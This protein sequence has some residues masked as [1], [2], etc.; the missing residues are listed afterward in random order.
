MLLMLVACLPAD[1][2]DP[3]PADED[4]VEDPLKGTA[5]L[6]EVTGGECP[7]LSDSGNV[8]LTSNG[9]ERT[10]KLFLPESGAEGAPVLFEWY[11]LG[12]SAGQIASYLDLRQYADETG[13]VVVVP[14][15]E[16]SNAFE[17]GFWNG[18]END[19]ALYD[20]L[21]TCLS[22]ELKV[23]LGRISANGMSAGGL[24]TSYLGDHRGD[25]LATILA[26][27]GGTDDSTFPYVAAA[28]AF[29]ALLVHGGE[30]DIYADTVN[31]RDATLDLAEHLDADGHLVIVCDHGG[32]HVIPA[33]GI[34]MMLSWLPA[35][36]FGEASPFATELGD[37]PQYCSYF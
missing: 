7:D 26:F 8:S 25:T 11:P 32:G 36:T 23:D 1:P 29:P 17:W 30:S 14:T 34:D 18:G 19:L 37:L 6:A 28:G 16:S 5:P 13:S 27:S 2:P 31:F 22:T 12:S 21:R 9:V 10:V 3:V 33:E 24:W 20:D 15:S 35:H 4:E